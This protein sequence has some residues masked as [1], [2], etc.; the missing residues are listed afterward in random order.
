MNQNI[1][2]QNDINNHDIIY[3]YC[4]IK[5][6]FEIIKTKKIWLSDSKF[7]NDKY[8]NTWLHK[9][10]EQTLEKFRTDF[11]EDQ[12]EAFRKKYTQID[13]EQKFISCFSYAGDR[14]SQWRAYANDGKGVAIGFSLEKLGLKRKSYGAKF[15]IYEGGSVSTEPLAY[16]NVVYDLKEQLKQVEN[17]VLHA[18]NSQEPIHHILT[19]HTTSTLY[20]HT[21]FSEENEIRI[22]YCPFLDDNSILGQQQFRESKDRIVPYYEFNFGDKTQLLSEVIIG[23][24]SE[25]SEDEMKIFLYAYGFSNVRIL[26]SESSY[27]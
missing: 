26:K 9:L 8:E 17:I 25:I 10:V 4:S 21:S 2:Y 12:I 6:F 24:K 27:Q 19:L 23:P 5:S 15:D 22:T 20:K 14:L 13:S 11:S 7:M 3:H 1:A 18:L 16:E